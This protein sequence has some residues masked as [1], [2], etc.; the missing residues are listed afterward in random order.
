RGKHRVRSRTF[1]LP[2]NGPVDAES[3]DELLLANLKTINANGRTALPGERCATGRTPTWD[4]AGAAH[5][6]AAFFSDVER[7]LTQRDFLLKV[8]VPIQGQRRSL[9]RSS[10]WSGNGIAYRR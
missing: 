9:C 1:F 10:I 2:A 3:Q 6:C 7:P 4:G 8:G 5:L